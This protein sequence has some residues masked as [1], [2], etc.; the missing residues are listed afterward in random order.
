[1]QRLSRR[2]AGLLAGTASRA[3]ARRP[4]A[5]ELSTPADRALIVHELAPDFDLV[6]VAPSARIVEV[7]EELVR[8]TE[9]QK[10][11]LEGLAE[12]PASSSGRSRNREDTDR[13]RRGDQAGRR[14]QADARS[15]ATGRGSPTTFDRRSSTTGYGRPPARADARADLA[16][17]AA[18]STS[19]RRAA[20]SVR[21]LLP[22]GRDRRA[23]RP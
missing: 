12:S 1:M 9:Q 15:S 22:A 4:P 8:L 6:P 20:R 19:V 5:G 13:V 21:H 2:L 11:L 14:R 23:R 17:P 18:G 16:R 3:R 10:Q 7:D